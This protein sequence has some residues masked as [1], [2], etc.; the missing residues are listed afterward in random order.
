MSSPEEQQSY[1]T[2]SQQQEPAASVSPTQ[3]ET[4]D[5]APAESNQ[6]YQTGARFYSRDQ[7]SEEEWKIHTSNLADQTYARYASELWS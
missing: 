2:Q 7:M 6:S 4:T 3:N 5:A 1:N